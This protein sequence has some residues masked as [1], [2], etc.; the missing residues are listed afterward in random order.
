MV[1]AQELINVQKEREKKKFITFEKVFSNIE[2]KIV[3]A[4]ASNFYYIWYEIPQYIIGFPLY[5]YVECIEYI[6]EKLKK[7]GFKIEKF[8]PNILLISWFP[9]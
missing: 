4:S 3:K 2:K 6:I 8:E 1:K 5:S 7:N 9:T